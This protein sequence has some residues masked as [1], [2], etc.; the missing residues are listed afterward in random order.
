MNETTD[1]NSQI[2]LVAIIA[3]YWAMLGS[4]SQLLSRW[5]EEKAKRETASA[6]R[7]GSAEHTSSADTPQDALR[8]V[9]PDFDLA[10]FLSGAKRAYEAILR[11]FADSD[12]QTLQ[13][14]VGPE[15]L[16]AF[17]REIVKRRDRQEM[18]ELTF[19]STDQA[20]VV[21]AFLGNGTAEIVVQYV[22]DVVSV[23]R[24][25]NNAVVAGDPRQIVEMIDTWT[26]A[27]ETQSKKRNW[28]LIATEGE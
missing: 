12:I 21:D 13:R 4:W 18:L 22:S 17:E 16:A 15:V 9:D 2:L 11:A 14:L 19:I 20:K 1:A 5:N 3:L 25:A 7:D 26:F 28:M 8:K 24:S 6:R 27:C 23:T 10:A